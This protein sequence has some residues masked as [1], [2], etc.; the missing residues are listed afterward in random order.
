MELDVPSAAVMTW[1]PL[2]GF[3]VLMR[4]QEQLNVLKLVRESKEKGM[5]KIVNIA[6]V[7]ESLEG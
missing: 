5:G 6:A 2:L 3:I 7:S 1:K 4:G